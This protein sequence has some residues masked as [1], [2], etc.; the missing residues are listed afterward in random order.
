[1]EQLLPRFPQAA[2][3]LA[4]AE[5]SL[6]FT[7]FPKERWRQHGRTTAGAAHREIRGRTDDVGFIPNRSSIIR[8][9][10]AP[11]MDARL[12]D[13]VGPALDVPEH[14]PKAG[15]TA[16]ARR[17]DVLGPRHG[18]R[19]GCRGELGVV[20]RSSGEDGVPRRPGLDGTHSYVADGQLLA[21][22]ANSRASRVAGDVELVF[23]GHGLP[24]PAGALVSAQR[25]YLLTLAAHVKELSDGRPNV[26]DAANA[27]IKR[28]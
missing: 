5:G 1:V 11:A 9:V 19:R 4:E 13:R 20:R 8:L 18:R 10:E 27:E 12:R 16:R 17:H 25:D 26:S 21:W 24:K 2:K 22:L 6:A 28:R 3:M 14:D 23:S 7:N 15:R